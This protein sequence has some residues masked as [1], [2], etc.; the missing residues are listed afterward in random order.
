[1]KRAIVKLA[2]TLGMSIVF[3]VNL[4]AQQSPIDK[5]SKMLAG[6]LSITTDNI[7]SD[8]NNYTSIIINPSIGVFVNRGFLLGGTLVFEHF[9]AGYGSETATGLGPEFRYYFNPKRSKA[10]IKGSIFPYLRSSLLYLWISDKIDGYYYFPAETHKS[11]Q[12][13]WSL[14]AGADYMLSN[15]VGL[16]FDLSVNAVNYKASRDDSWS[17]DSAANLSAGFT[18]F[19]Y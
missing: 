13:E 19:L 9:P 6:G 11:N 12:F 15:A 16:F 7:N 18:F 3:V 2:I 5:G 10:E 4:A 1:M 14:G 17:T 8:R